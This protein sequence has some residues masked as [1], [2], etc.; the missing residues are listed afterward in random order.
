MKTKVKCVNKNVKEVIKHVTE[1]MKNP[2]PT[3][4]KTG[5]AEIDNYFNGFYPNN[6]S[7]FLGTVPELNAI[8]SFLIEGLKPKRNVLYI[9]HKDNTPFKYPIKPTLTTPI[10]DFEPQTIIT[11]IEESK[12]WGQMDFI[13]IAF[14]KQDFAMKRYTKTLDLITNIVQKENSHAV[15]C[16]NSPVIAEEVS[17]ASHSYTMTDEPTYKERRTAKWELLHNFSGCLE[18]YASN[19]FVLDLKRIHTV[20]SMVIGKQRDGSSNFY[21][22]FFKL[23]PNKMITPI[24]S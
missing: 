9:H 12:W 2:K 13:I 5:Y 16:I 8:T 14:N 17:R 19:I 20:L 11:A 18:A 21:E 6:L 23:E 15:F 3:A 4:I 10:S 22:I 7:V 1:A 24:K